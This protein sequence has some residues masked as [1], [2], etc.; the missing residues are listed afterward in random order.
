MSPS[1]I[2]VTPPA[3]GRP[4]WRH[5]ASSML[6]TVALL[7]PLAIS[8]CGP[9]EDLIDEIHNRGGGSGGGG[10][11]ADGGVTNPCAAA[12]CLVGSHCEVQKPSVCKQAPCPPVAVCVADPKP[13]AGPTCGGIAGKACPGM[14]KCVDDPSDSCDPAKGGADCG[15]IC[16]CVQSALCAKGTKFDSSPSVCACVPDM[17]PP[18]GPACGGFTGKPCPGMGKCVD[19]PSDSCDPAKGGADCGG[20]CSCVETVLC[21]QGTKFDSSPSVCACVPEKPVCGPVCDIYCT[22]GNVLDAQGCPTCACNKPTPGA[23]CPTDQCMGPG[24]KAAT[25]KCSDGKTIG[26]PACVVDANGVCNWTVVACPA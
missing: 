24:P 17:T 7:A 11:G 2:A 15:G 6:F 18:S 5:V 25:I 20:I 1:H 3:P 14:G 12:L 19:D 9:L 26:G 16:T 21:K 8:G 22:F 10:S 13:P 4:R 23:T